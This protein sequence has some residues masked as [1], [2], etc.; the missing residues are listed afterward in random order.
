MHDFEV[1]GLQ[2]AYAAAS[3]MQHDIGSYR[4][5]RI[6]TVLGVISFLVIKAGHSAGTSG[7]IFK[8]LCFQEGSLAGEVS[9]RKHLSGIL[10]TLCIYIYIRRTPP[11]CNSGIIGI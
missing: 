8:A 7:D 2:P 3:K 9:A 11:P 1:A 6:A 4:Q 5:T 10:Q